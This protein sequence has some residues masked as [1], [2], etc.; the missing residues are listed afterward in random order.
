MIRPP[1]ILVA[2]ALI[3]AWAAMA[4][5]IGPLLPSWLVGLAIIILG[6]S[7]GWLLRQILNRN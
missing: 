1:K 3:A 5:A 6:L 2:L 7:L 4:F